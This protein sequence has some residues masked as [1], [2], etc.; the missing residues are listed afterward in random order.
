DSIRAAV[1]PRLTGAY[2]L[3]RQTPAP[4]TAAGAASAASAA[5]SSAPAAAVAKKVGPGVYESYGG[6][7]SNEQDTIQRDIARTFPHH[8]LFRDI[9]PAGDPAGIGA[10]IGGSG[11]GDGSSNS[12]K[13]D[14]AEGKNSIGRSALYHVLKAYS[15]HDSQVGYCQGMGFP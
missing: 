7:H 10:G 3:M 8:V 5:A 12:S 6:M 15:I 2:E 1:W 9:N 14:D 4:P 13:V 11:G